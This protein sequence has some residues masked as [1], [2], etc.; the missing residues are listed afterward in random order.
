MPTEPTFTVRYWGITGSFSAPLLPEQVTAKVVESIEYLARQGRLSGLG[1]VPGLREAIEREVSMLPFHLR[2][3]YGGNTTC[4]EVRTSDALIIIDCGSGYRELG[5]LLTKEWNA[6]DYKGRRD[7]HI[8]LTHPH[9]DHTFATAFFAPYYDPRNHFTIYATPHVIGSLE[10]VFNPNSKLSNTYFP[11]TFA[12]LKAIE[13]FEPI[14]AGQEFHIGSTRIST[15]PLRHPGGCIAFK[16]ERHGRSCVFASDH[17]QEEVP[18]KGLADFCRGAD[19]LY[20]EGQYTQ[21]EYDGTQALPGEALMPRKGWGHSPIEACVR[22]A[23]AAGVRRLHLGH[24]DPVRSDEDL[25]WLEDF[26]RQLARDELRSAGRDPESC[27]VVIPP[28]GF[29]VEI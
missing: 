16:L 4:A 3:T 17:E 26:A 7:A 12:L 10:A 28:E 2:S 24:R 8:L 25:A 6:P 18:D 19:L 23:L 29:T 5:R 20:T 27:D 13:R 21:A 9:M 1:P 22:T 14:C 15:F 11:P